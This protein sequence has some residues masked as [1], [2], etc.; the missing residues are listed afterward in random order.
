MT[1]F[2]PFQSIREALSA[3]HKGPREEEFQNIMAG[4]YAYGHDHVDELLAKAA[5]LEKCLVFYYKNEKDIECDI[6][7]YKFERIDYFK[8]MNKD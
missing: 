4:A 8:K 1:P 7:S 3:E 5:K 2:T 6:L